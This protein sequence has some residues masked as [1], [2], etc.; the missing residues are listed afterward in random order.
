MLPVQGASVRPVIRFVH[1]LNKN[2]PNYVLHEIKITNGDRFYAILKPPAELKNVDQFETEVNW[3]QGYD[4]INFVRVAQ[5]RG[6]VAMYLGE[7]QMTL[8][9]RRD[10]PGRG[11]AVTAR[12]DFQNATKEFRRL[13]PG[14]DGEVVKAPLMRNPVPVSAPPNRA[15]R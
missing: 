15:F 7:I 10:G 3:G 14:F 6:A 8:A 9:E 2:A 4:K 11:L 12:D 1:Q 13:Y 5:K